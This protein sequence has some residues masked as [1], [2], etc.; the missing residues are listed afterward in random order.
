MLFF[1]DIKYVSGSVE[2][3]CGLGLAD[4]VIDLVETGTTMVVRTIVPYSLHNCIELTVFPSLFQLLSILIT[5][6]FPFIFIKYGINHSF[7]ISN[8]LEIF[9][10]P[11]F[12][13]L[14]FAQYSL[15]CWSACGG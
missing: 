2:A 13:L 5:N 6:P 1:T 12:D 9:D 4:A 7:V 3:A 11:Y 10:C 15:G 14:Q 8:I